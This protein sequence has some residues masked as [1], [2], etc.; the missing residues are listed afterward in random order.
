[1]YLE[2]WLL[3]QHC[4][5]LRGQNAFLLRGVYSRPMQIDGFQ[6]CLRHGSLSSQTFDVMKEYTSMTNVH[7]LLC[8]TSSHRAFVSAV[9]VECLD[10]ILQ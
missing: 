10:S 3:M 2:A 7:P 6:N 4:E 9:P 5:Y 1:M 8:K